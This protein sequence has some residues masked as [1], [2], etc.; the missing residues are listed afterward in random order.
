MQPVPP[1]P[2]RQNGMT[3]IEV[4][5]ATVLASF[6]IMAGIDVY[7]TISRASVKLEGRDS[8]FTR[9]LYIRD[10]VKSL[11]QGL[12]RYLNPDP[13]DFYQQDKLRFI[14]NTSIMG[15]KN[16][17]PHVVEYTLK[18]DQILY[19]EK[20]LTGWLTKDARSKEKIIAQ[21]E[22]PALFIAKQGKQER[23]FL[24]HLSRGKFEYW[25]PSR[26]EFIDRWRYRTQHPHLFK[27]SFYIEG[28]KTEWVFSFP[29]MEHPK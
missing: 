11:D 19:R 25:D 18:E 16:N 12:T 1:T 4:V 28:K 23:F 7:Q 22:S 13:K 5:L 9:E 10:Q 14:T 20:P 21:L 15:G 8:F 29:D 17:Q 2:N 26:Q 6:V 24:S 3:L 27:I